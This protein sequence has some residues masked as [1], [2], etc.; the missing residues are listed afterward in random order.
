MPL[1]PTIRDTLL[2]I[3]SASADN[4]QVETAFADMVS[5]AVANKAGPLLQNGRHIGFEIIKQNEDNTH[6]LGVS[7]FRLGNSSVDD[8][9]Y[10]PVI[11]SN[12]KLVCTNLLYRV[13][14]KKFTPFKPD[15]CQF[16]LDLSS[17]TAGRPILKTET[18]KLTP[19]TN[20]HML[21]SPP[22]VLKSATRST[23]KEASSR[24][25]DPAAVDEMLDLI[26]QKASA[27]PV[28]RDFMVSAGIDALQ[29]LDNTCA[30]RPKFAAALAQLGEDVFMPAELVEHA[31]ANNQKRAAA[32]DALHMPTLLLT[33]GP[34][35]VE[36]CKRASVNL[37]EGMIGRLFKVGYSID[38]VLNT[39]VPEHRTL[40]YEGTPAAQFMSPGPA[41]KA[42][43][44]L[45]GGATAD[46]VVGNS[47]DV[48][49]LFSQGLAMPAGCAQMCGGVDSPRRIAVALD[50]PAFFEGHTPLFLV[51]SLEEGLATVGCSI[52]DIEAPGMFSLVNPGNDSITRPVWID[53]AKKGE[54]GVVELAVAT[55]SGGDIRTL[56]FNPS[57][58]QNDAGGNGVLG[59][60]W[61]AV[62]L[63]YKKTES[64]DAC[65]AY[66][67]NG[68]TSKRAPNWEMQDLL[69]GV[70]GDLRNFINELPNLKQ[71]SLVYENGLFDLTVGDVA[72][73]AESRHG[74]AVKLACLQVSPASIEQLLDSA[75]ANRRAEFTLDFEKT[76]GMLQVIDQ[77]R[78][79]QRFDSVHN[80]QLEV[81][82]AF[83][84]RTYKSPVM[85]PA[86]R[87]GDR[88]E[89]IGRDRN[90]DVHDDTKAHE[91]PADLILNGSPEDIGAHAQSIGAPHVFDH[92]VLGSLAR[93][94]DSAKLLEG[95]IPKLEDGVDYLG[96]SIF[97][98]YWRPEDWRNLYGK[99]DLP[100]IEQ[101]LNS[102]FDNMGDVVLD[103]LKKTR[104][105]AAT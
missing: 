28:L 82:Q 94:Y 65:P 74:A 101:K 59:P 20:W 97:L 4:K 26:M 68:G 12:G 104:T 51:P 100:E 34:P 27:A 67:G 21:S 91:V 50:K 57:L 79:Q 43:L 61:R 102:V 84:L 72:C 18:A 33:V 76:A 13:G 70:D 56:L 52:K 62:R 103:L 44:L 42:K 85:L 60:A 11:F 22:G 87:I 55:Y 39:P 66:T 58:R 25:T 95:F 88:L 77:P 73:P 23:A 46:V 69:P 17:R 41:G 5:V 45:A 2:K 8:L 48:Y 54:D 30:A 81:P 86:P 53:S 90:R 16:L 98:F 29:I 93:T 32:E 40:A 75:T 7:V 19:M 64:A 92:A 105:A 10:A 89:P 47:Q 37:D 14:P 24:I 35:D 83:A 49:E 9:V 80:V 6:M 15:W 71:A 1:A 31:Q 99:D 78:W 3:S 96:R 63:P 38:P 36:L